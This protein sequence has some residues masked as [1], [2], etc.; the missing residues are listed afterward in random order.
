MG[1]KGKK[2]YESAGRRLRIAR[3]IMGKT[4]NSLRLDS[5]WE[6]IVGLEDTGSIGIW[7]R[8]G[9]PE[10]RLKSLAEFLHV[11]EDVLTDLDMKDE[12]FI[13]IFGIRKDNPEADISDLLQTKIGKEDLDGLE[14]TITNYHNKVHGARRIKELQ[15]VFV[16]LMMVEDQEVTLS[17][18]FDLDRTRPVDE[19]LRENKETD[20]RDRKGV[21]LELM[22]Q[23]PQL[24]LLGEPGTGKTTYLEWYCFYLIDAYQKGG[25]T[26]IYVPLVK[27]RPG[28]D[29]ISLVSQVSEIPKNHLNHFVD[30]LIE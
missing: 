7:E 27:Y 19:G 8:K 26:A 21:I 3:N 20:Q 24:V 2:L 14:T 18:I 28:M 12:V 17:M 1:R 15:D 4:Q 5:R 25:K 13:K 16:P 9:V 30:F 6:T 11:T 22:R 10:N 23:E 29:L